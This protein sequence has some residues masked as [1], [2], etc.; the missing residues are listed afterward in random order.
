MQK[1]CLALAFPAPLVFLASLGCGLLAHRLI[2]A[3]IPLTPELGRTA[4]LTGIAGAALLGI[5]ALRSL[6]LAGEDPNPRVPTQTI[7]STGPYAFSRNPIYLAFTLFVA[8]ISFQV[9]TIWAILILPLGLAFLHYGVISREEDYLE[10]R[11]VDEYRQYRA[12]V[13]RWL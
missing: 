12:S 2:P 4:G 7:V 9:N 3:A 1:D 11:F 8:G 13:R 10:R 5:W 6:R